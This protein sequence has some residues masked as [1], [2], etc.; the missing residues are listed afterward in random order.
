MATGDFRDRLLRCLGGEWPPAG[1]LNARTLSTE[2]LEGG[3]RR[4]KVTYEVEPGE[5]APAYLLLPAGASR[6]KPLPGICVWHQHN[7]AWS[8]GASEPAGV[9]GMPM[10]QTG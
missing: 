10:H 1:P 2:E 3:V 5:A 6:E 7:G 9:G 4:E 8:V